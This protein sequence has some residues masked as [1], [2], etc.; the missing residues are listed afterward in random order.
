M[1]GVARCERS[2]EVCEEQ[3][4]VRGAERCTRSRAV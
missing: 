3:I 2:R 1:R 4:G